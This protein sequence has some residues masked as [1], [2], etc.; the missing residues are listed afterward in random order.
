MN[1]VFVQLS[2]GL[3][4]QMFQYATARAQSLNNNSPLIVDIWSGFVRDRQYK[5]VFA[6]ASFPIHW[7]IAT[8][9]DYISLYFYRLQ[10]KL[11]RPQRLLDTNH[12]GR[13]FYV[14]QRFQFEPLLLR[15]Q[16]TKSTWLIGYW[17]TPKYFAAHE[18]LLRKE[19]MP[20]MPTKGPFLTLHELVRGCESVAIGI[21]LYEESNDPSAH[22]HEGKIKTAVDV[23]KAI[24][25]VL[26][27][28]PSAKF[29]VFCTHRANYLADLDLPADTIYVTADEGFSNSVE[30]LWLIA[31]CKHHI[32]TNSSYYWWGAWL[33]E[34]IHKKEEQLVFAADNF[35]N[36][37]G[38]CDYWQRF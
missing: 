12:C 37:D 34:A 22:A 2:G 25:R 28:R 23:N 15:R 29:F 33:S 27:S 5:R 20:P 19:L 1:K 31:Q 35:I 8:S 9:W 6:L 18:A 24:A 36:T 21:R 10:T 13:D 11:G 14:E 26:D 4:N 30:C 16:L 3:G 32:F 7:R 17:Q 38:L